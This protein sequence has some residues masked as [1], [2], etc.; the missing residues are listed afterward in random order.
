MFTLIR[1]FENIIIYFIVK[2]KYRKTANN[3]VYYARK[4]LRAI[5]LC[6]FLMFLINVI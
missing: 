5:A 2:N 3:I 4:T 1:N 6:V